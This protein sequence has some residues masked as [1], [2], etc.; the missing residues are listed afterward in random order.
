MRGCQLSWGTD[1]AMFYWGNPKHFDKS[2]T[3]LFFSAIKY[4]LFDR[5]GETGRLPCRI[6][7]A[8]L[9]ISDGA[10]LRIN[11]RKH[12]RASMNALD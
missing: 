12:P 4:L 5:N 6:I 3:E 1:L 11:L 7:R 10:S 8:Q 2:A 9:L